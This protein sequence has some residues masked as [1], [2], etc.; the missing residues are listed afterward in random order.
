MET[1]GVFSIWNRH[2]G[3]SKLIPLHLNTYVMGLRPVY[4]FYFFWGQSPR[5]E[6]VKPFLICF[7]LSV[8]ER[9]YFLWEGSRGSRILLYNRCGNGGRLI[10]WE[11]RGVHCG[12]LHII[13]EE[14]G[15]PVRSLWSLAYSCK[16]IYVYSE[17][18]VVDFGSIHSCIK[19]IH[20]LEGFIDS[21]NNNLSCGKKRIKA[22]GRSRFWKP[23]IRLKKI[24]NSRGSGRFWELQTPCVIAKTG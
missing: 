22:K 14:K 18:E 17:R 1:T 4:I 15:V 19:G 10:F 8:A 2:K 24:V 3:F 12:A 7:V 6:R 5:A 9:G 23:S 20:I 11:E 16:I 21:S 13:V